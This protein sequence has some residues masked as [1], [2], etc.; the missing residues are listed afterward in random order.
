[1]ELENWKT[2]KEREDEVVQLFLPETCAQCGGYPA[3]WHEWGDPDLMEVDVLCD[4]CYAD[5]LA[6]AGLPATARASR[7]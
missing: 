3:A 2:N 6:A 4:A 1:M 5:A 7:Q